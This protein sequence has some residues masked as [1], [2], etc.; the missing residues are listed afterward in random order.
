VIGNEFLLFEFGREMFVAF[1]LFRAM[2]KVFQTANEQRMAI[3]VHMR[4]SISKQR[5]YGPE[6]ARLFLE[7][8]SFASDIPVQIAHLAASGLGFNDPSAHSVLEVL[9]E[10]VGKKRPADAE[11]LVRCN[12]RRRSR[13]FG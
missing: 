6:Q 12:D 9:A 7:L 10:A 8:L 1:E 5:P 4:A 11:S 2:L 13:K 3:V